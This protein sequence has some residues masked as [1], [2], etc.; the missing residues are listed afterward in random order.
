MSDQELNEAAFA[1][2]WTEYYR[3]HDARTALAAAI[4][5]YLRVARISG[6]DQANP[7]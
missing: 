1:A 2:A 4:E 3:F 5:E 7:R 6:D